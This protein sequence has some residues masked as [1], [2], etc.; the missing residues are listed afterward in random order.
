[1]KESVL[2]QP[3]RKVKLKLGF[4]KKDLVLTISLLLAAASCFIHP[5]KLEYINFHVLGSLF[6]LMLA[7]KAF[8][9]LRLL[10]KFAIGLLNKCQN[11]KSVSTILIL[12]CFFSSMFVTNDVAL[13][14]FVPLT[15]VI[16]KKANLPMMETIILQ[17]IAANLGS[18]LTPMGNPQ[19]LFIYSYYE[20]TPKSFFTTVLFLAILGISALYFF[21][22]KLPKTELKVEMTPVTKVDRKQAMIWGLVLAII[23]ASIFGVI[24]YQVAVIIT[25][26]TVLKLNRKLLKQIE[27]LLLLTFICFFIFSGN[28]SNSA[29]VQS[30]ATERLNN[31]TSVYFSSILLSQLISNVP[32]SIFLASFT[33]DWKPLLLGVNIGGL[34][35]IIASLASVI[36]YKLFI[37]TH[38]NEGK[39]YLIKFSFYNVSFLVFL[40]LIQYFILKI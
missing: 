23:I 40:T 28:I 14:T 34:G 3:K 24:H 32:A 2:I 22:R 1:V 6:N 35:T 21:I 30:L 38:P 33:T 17:T 11:S 19:N 15:I 10:D 5:P 36:S 39:R 37:Q 16:G 25:L 8:E 9:E 20:I 4:L 27:Y 29:V 18:S 13:L 31:S 12:L 26:I 7:I